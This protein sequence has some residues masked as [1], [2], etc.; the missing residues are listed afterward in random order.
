MFKCGLQLPASRLPFQTAISIEKFFD[1]IETADPGCTFEIKSRT[2]VSQKY[3]GLTTS[4]RQT[5]RHRALMISGTR[6]VIDIRAMVQQYLHERI[7]HT[8]SKRVNTGANQTKRSRSATVHICLRI[9]ISA[10]IQQ[11][12]GDL[13]YVPGCLLTISF[14]AI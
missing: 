3:S 13:N 1:D 7:L 10:R 12:F 4:V 9:N 14:D 5:S 2:T 6:H 8:S 11:H